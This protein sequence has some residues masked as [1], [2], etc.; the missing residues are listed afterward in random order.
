MQP[1]MVMIKT[2]FHFQEK[3][4][5]LCF[6]SRIVTGL[7]KGPSSITIYFK[8]ERS[9]LHFKFHFFWNLERTDSICL[10]PTGKK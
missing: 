4:S 3:S 6:H 5:Y 2:Q 8:V 1:F 10:Q 9:L 7:A